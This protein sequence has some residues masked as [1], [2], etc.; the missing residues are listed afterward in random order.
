MSSRNP[1]TS[2]GQPVALDYSTGVRVL[3]AT[4]DVERQQGRIGSSGK[5]T[6]RWS[7]AV[8]VNSG[9]FWVNRKLALATGDSTLQFVKVRVDLGTAV[10]DIG[11]MPDPWPPF[12]VWYEVAFW[13]GDVIAPA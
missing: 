2:R 12:E 1:D 6:P 4:Q 5:R 3:Q 10:Y 8:G 7:G 9:R 11:P 13:P